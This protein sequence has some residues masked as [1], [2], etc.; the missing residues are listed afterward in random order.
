M[1]EDE[2]PE[3]TYS[4]G[5]EKISSQPEVIVTGLKKEIAHWVVNKYDRRVKIREF[6]TPGEFYSHFLD[7]FEVTFK[8]VE[9]KYYS[10]Y[11]GWGKWQYNGENFMVLQLIYPGTSGVWPCEVD[12]P[13]DFTWFVPKLY[14]S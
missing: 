8:E 7:G 2:H 11:F 1:E 4:I 9:K 6:F 14:A 10:E 5:I 12:A 13:E 3:F